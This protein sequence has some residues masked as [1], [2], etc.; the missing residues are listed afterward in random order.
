MP[1]RIQVFRRQAFDRQGGR[2][3]YCH[4]AIWQLTPDELPAK[5]PSPRAAARPRCTAEHL[6]PNFDG[7]QDSA[8]NLVAACLQC[9]WTRH[10]R[11]APPSP[12]AF[13]RWVA[14]R[15]RRGAWHQPWVFERGLLSAAGL[16]E[17]LS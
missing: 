16:P 9:N 11:K 17:R 6:V 5:A 3:Y 1:S 12:E 2:C 13:R 10:R 14:A 7:G 15:V 8:A 4:A